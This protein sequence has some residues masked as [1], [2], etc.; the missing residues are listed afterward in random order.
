[1]FECHITIDPVPGE[2]L[3][4]A[5]T[6]ARDCGFKIA[7]LLMQNRSTNTVERCMYDTF[8]TGHDSYKLQLEGRMRRLCF[9]LSSAGFHVW[10]YKIEEIILDS[11]N[12]DDFGL[13]SKTSVP[14]PKEPA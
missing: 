14:P 5:Q 1:M 10:R 3:N 7:N 6:L 12:G 4:L 9:A 2:R 11:R 13:L 8:M